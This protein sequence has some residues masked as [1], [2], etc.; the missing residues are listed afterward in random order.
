MTHRYCHACAGWKGT[1]H[2]QDGR[3]QHQGLFEK[4]WRRRWDLY[5]AWCFLKSGEWSRERWSIYRGL[6][7]CRQNDVYLWQEVKEQEVKE[8]WG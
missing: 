8:R 3:Y 1:P 5:M 6:A 4:F 7:D 2:V